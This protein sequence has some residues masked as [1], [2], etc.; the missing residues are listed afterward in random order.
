MEGR[1][2]KEENDGCSI[3][4]YGG[5]LVIQTLWEGMFIPFRLGD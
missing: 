2:P 3:E 1:E 4:V 5:G